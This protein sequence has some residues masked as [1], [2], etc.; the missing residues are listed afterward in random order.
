MIIGI[1]TIQSLL[2]FSLLDWCLLGA[3]AAVFV[4]Q[5]Y[6]YIRYMAGVQRRVRHQQKLR[7]RWNPKRQERQA[8]KALEVAEKAAREAG[9][10]LVQ[11]SCAI[12]S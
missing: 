8:G 7:F 3:L 10:E 2:S 1:M 4:Y 11:R 12:W 5:L 6:Y 9:L